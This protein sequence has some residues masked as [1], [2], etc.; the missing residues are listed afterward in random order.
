MPACC[1]GTPVRTACDESATFAAPHEVVESSEIIIGDAADE[2]PMR[3]P[4]T[5]SG[6]PGAGGDSVEGEAAPQRSPVTIRPLAP[7]PRTP[8]EPPAEAATPAADEPGVTPPVPSSPPVPVSPEPVMRPPVVVEEPAPKAQ[9]TEEGPALPRPPAPSRPEAE[10]PDDAALPK[11]PAP[12]PVS[13]VPAPKP[14]EPE[15]PM[16]P[17][18][19]RTP[20]AP[21]DEEDL[22]E[23]ATEPAPAKPAMPAAPAAE[24][25]AP[26]KEP[27][28]GE[29]L[30]DIFNDGGDAK[31]PATAE[32]G[33]VAEPAQ[34]TPEPEQP[35]AEPDA[36][37]PSKEEP[38]T[39][40]EEPAA[41]ETD[42]F[43]VVPTPREPVRLWVDDTGL[44]EV[45]G[46]LVSIGRGTARIL[47][48]NGRHTTVPL[49]QLSEH[50]R[51]YVEA[52]ANR[53]ASSR[54]PPAERTAGL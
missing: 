9:P 29:S 35:T 46:R 32:A 11:P 3:Q 25:P 1:E 12:A 24:K 8:S 31:K 34:P 7:A 13:D 51:F 23:D 18:E 16:K 14:A 33:P 36:T 39:E 5:R 54:I 41:S 48:S 50:D 44:Y 53:I 2:E 37:E 47:K 21:K 22:F 43:A 45:T 4:E 10:M 40:Q 17:A 20:A 49:E 27:K 42:P 15:A 6:V 30:D 28:P 38:A 26:T 19:P 52:T